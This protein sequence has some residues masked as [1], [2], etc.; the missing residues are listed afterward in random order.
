MNSNNFERI[1]RQWFT[2]F[3]KF[4]M[5]YYISK[6]SDDFGR[7]QV[8]KIPKLQPARI[9]MHILQER[10]LFMQYFSVFSFASFGVWYSI[11]YYS[12]QYNILLRKIFDSEV[13]FRQTV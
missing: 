8:D 12:L 9:G 10:F 13:G 5:E 3:G 6:L 2:I 4:G 1:T 11:T 7:I